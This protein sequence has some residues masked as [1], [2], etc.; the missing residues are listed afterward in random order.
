MSQSKQGRRAAAD[1][2]GLNIYPPAAGCNGG[3]LN[4]AAGGAGHFGKGG[5]I[6]LTAGDAFDNNSQGGSILFT[7]G[8]SQFGITS[9]PGHIAFF[10]CAAY[11]NGPSEA[12]RIDSNGNVGVHTTTPA[13]A[14]DVNGTIA[15][16][17]S[18]IVDASGIRSSTLVK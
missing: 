5:D 11:G 10:C 17:S 16:N 13:A 1:G 14:L 15:I 9:K 18:P 8:G 4:L 2:S 6:T 3:N 7:A 12:M